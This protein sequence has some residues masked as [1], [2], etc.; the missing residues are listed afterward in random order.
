MVHPPTPE[1]HHQAGLLPGGEHTFACQTAVIYFCTMQKHPSGLNTI[2]FEDK[3]YLRA[4]FPSE[5]SEIAVAMKIIIRFIVLKSNMV[6]YKNNNPNRILE[7][8]I[9]LI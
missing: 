8:D 1:S 4:I 9:M 2:I 7:A 5:M 3:P 6:K